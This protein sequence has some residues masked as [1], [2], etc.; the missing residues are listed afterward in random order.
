ML[1][2]T[3]RNTANPTMLEAGYKVNVIPSAAHGAS[4]TAASCPGYEDEFLRQVDALLGDG[5]RRASSCTAT[6]A[7]G[8][9]RSTGALVDAMTAALRAEDPTARRCRT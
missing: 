4:S 9:R 7:A 3:L 2:A 6:S 5:V 1:G 8:D